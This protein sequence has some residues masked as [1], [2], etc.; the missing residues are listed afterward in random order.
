MSNLNVEPWDPAR[1][2]RK[3]RFESKR[4]VKTVGNFWWPRYLLVIQPTKN[5]PF[6]EDVPSQNWVF[7]YQLWL[8]GGTS[9]WQSDTT[10]YKKEM[11]EINDVWLS[12]HPNLPSKVRELCPK[13]G[14]LLTWLLHILQKFQGPSPFAALLTSAEGGV[15][16][17]LERLQLVSD[18]VAL[19]QYELSNDMGYPEYLWMSDILSVM[20]HTES[21][22][23]I[24]SKFCIA[25][26]RITRHVCTI[27][28]IQ[29]DIAW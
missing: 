25:L 6:L 16:G 19:I 2:K 7:H 10:W 26:H 13:Y 5:P 27:V 1:S 11:K 22:R 14:S 3:L 17:N 9:L 4:A 23:Y 15:E 28:Y 24:R 29:R 21:H 12:R 18:P 20:V 8:P